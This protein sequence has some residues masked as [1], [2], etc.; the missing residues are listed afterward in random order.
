LIDAR[1][2]QVTVSLRDPQASWIAVDLPGCQR[3]RTHPG[4]RLS[5]QTLFNFQLFEVFREPWSNKRWWPETDRLPF[6]TLPGR[7]TEL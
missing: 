6:S 7:S 2:G 4:G 5:E 1:S 3:I